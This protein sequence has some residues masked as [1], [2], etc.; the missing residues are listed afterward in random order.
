M[1]GR[2]LGSP[3]GYISEDILSMFDDLGYSSTEDV[4]AMITEFQKDH[5]IIQDEKDE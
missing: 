2:V 1:Y 4:R 5:S 3:S